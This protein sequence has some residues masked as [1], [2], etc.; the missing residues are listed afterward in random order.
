MEYDHELSAGERVRFVEGEIMPQ[1][2]ADQAP[3]LDSNIWTKA[4]LNKARR[5]YAMEYIRNGLTEL[6]PMIGADRTCA[7]GNITAQLI[8]RQFYPE[9]ME[10]LELDF[11]DRSLSTFSRFMTAMA[12]AHDDEVVIISHAGGGMTITQ[13]GWRLTRGMADLPPVIFDVWNALWEG[14]LC[15]HDRMRRLAVVK[16]PAHADDS[17][18]WTIT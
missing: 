2:D 12:S 5:N 15:A 18:T 8:G 1:F 3:M 4:R 7:V 10:I 14:C 13:T 16:A 17:V 6:I 9:I 11:A